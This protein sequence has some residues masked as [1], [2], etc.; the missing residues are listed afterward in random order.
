MNDKLSTDVTNRALGVLVGSATGDALGAAYEFNRVLP[1]DFIPEMLGGGLMPSR[2]PGGWTDDTAMANCLGLAL[3][4]S[5]DLNFQ[6][7]VARQF[8][9]WF[10]SH[11]EDMGLQTR[12]VI[13][14]ASLEDTIDAQSF[15]AASK[16][17]HQEIGRSG[18][19]GALMRI[20]PVGIAALGAHRDTTAKLAKDSSKLTHWDDDSAFACS[21]W[22]TAI[23]QVVLT[24]ELPDFYWLTR[25]QPYDDEIIMRWLHLVD[26]AL[27]KPPAAFDDNGYVVRTLQACLSVLS[28]L[29][30]GLPPQDYFREG[31]YHVIRIGDDTDTT[32]AV[33][34]GILG[35][36][37]GL[38]FIPEEWKTILHG[39][40]NWT[41]HDL[42]ELALKILSAQN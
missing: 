34:G 5:N 15:R 1:P 18:G 38:S 20:A 41:G 12:S 6:D 39:W 3:A 7:E 36:K 29:P 32:A 37:V 8:H 11:P 33:L 31:L 4:H 25:E 26:E 21:L 24:G 2:R 19:N 27:K 22:A 35:A 16:A 40:P 42:E 9:R 10:F 17:H 23:Q 13:S 28:C 14:R 30:Q